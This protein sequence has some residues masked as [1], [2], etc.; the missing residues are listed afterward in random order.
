MKNVRFVTSRFVMTRFILTLTKVWFALTIGTDNN[1]LVR[2][3]KTKNNATKMFTTANFYV[4]MNLTNSKRP[5]GR[6]V[7]TIMEKMIWDLNQMAKNPD[8]KCK[9]CL[10]SFAKGVGYYT[11]E[12][13]DLVHASCQESSTAVLAESTDFEKMTM[14]ELV[15]AW[16]MKTGKKI[17][18]FTSKAVGVKRL[19]ELEEKTQANDMIFCPG[20]QKRI[21]LAG[22]ETRQA[23]K[24]VKCPKECGRVVAK[25]K[26][27]SKAK[28]PRTDSKKAKVAAC[29]AEKDTWTIDELMA[30]SGFDQPNLM[31]MMSIFQNPKRTKA[32]EIITTTFDKKVRTYT[33]VEAERVEKSAPAKKPR[34]K[35]EKAA[36]PVVEE[37]ATSAE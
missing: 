5:Q 6:K 36:D 18:A 27:E 26:A 10:C 9:V 1:Y 33:R 20:E 15:A 25:P 31:C 4:T 24:K 30:A 11:L 12:N 13:G 7:G 17:K 16:E 28:T 37:N 23:G 35:K 14:E 3:G 34:A 32:G 29:F 22:C 19:T 8:A 2:R 21:P